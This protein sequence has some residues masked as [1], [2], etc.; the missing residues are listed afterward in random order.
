LF[1]HWILLQC[2][3]VIPPADGSYGPV[4]WPHF[5][6]T[7]SDRLVPGV[8]ITAVR[9]EIRALRDSRGVGAVADCNKRFSDLI[10]MQ[11]NVS[12]NTDKNPLYDDYCS[13]H[14]T[15]IA[16]QTITPARIKKNM[17]PATLSTLADAMEMGGE[18]SECTTSHPAITA[19]PVNHGANIVSPNTATDPTLVGPEPMNLTVAN[20]NTR[21]YRWNC[22]GHEARY[23]VTPETRARGQAFRDRPG[24]NHFK[25][26]SGCDRTTTCRGGQG[27]SARSA[28]WGINN[29][30]AAA[31]DDASVQDERREFGSGACVWGCRGRPGKW[32]LGVVVERPTTQEIIG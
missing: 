4:M 29:V 18:F 12:T 32:H 15:R 8:A 30:P 11:H 1:A 10:H 16:D 3:M 7:L 28:A 24:Q 5:E 13:K 6:S 14:P 21:C 9:K 19:T 22:C 31:V 27:T 20:A 26:D 25:R 17:Q 2:V 23:C